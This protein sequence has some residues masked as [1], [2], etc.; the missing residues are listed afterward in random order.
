[1]PQFV[2][3]TRLVRT[4]AVGTLIHNAGYQVD[5]IPSLLDESRGA[6]TECGRMTFALL[7]L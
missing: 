5:T 7:F 4:P 1:M 3:L 6:L 2:D